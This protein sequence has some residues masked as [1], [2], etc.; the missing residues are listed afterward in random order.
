MAVG[1][2]KDLCSLLGANK[3]LFHFLTSRLH[4]RYEKAE[5]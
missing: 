1:F 4:S 2:A 5:A 3:S